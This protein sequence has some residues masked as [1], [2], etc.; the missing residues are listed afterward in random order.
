MNMTGWVGNF[1]IL[2]QLIKPSKILH[3]IKSNIS[4]IP[5]KD[6][7]RKD[8]THRGRKSRKGNKRQ[9]AEDPIEEESDDVN[10][11]GEEDGEDELEDEDEYE[12]GEDEMDDGDDEDEMEDVDE[13]GD[14]EISDEIV[15]QR[16]TRAPRR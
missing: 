1:D 14:T 9:K 10:E 8:P 2:N 3:K 11:D 6:V 12:D 4:Q 5:E 15:T 7:E 13:D 16:T